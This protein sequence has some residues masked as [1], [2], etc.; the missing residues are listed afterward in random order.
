MNVM[1]PMAGRGSRFSAEGYRRPKP[2]INIVG[3]PMLFWILDNL[4]FEAE[5]TLWVGVH[6]ELEVEYAIEARLRKEYPSLDLR[7]VS[8]GFQTRGAAETLFIMLQQM[9]SV[10]VRRKSISLDC[11][12]IFFSDV[13]GSFRACSSGCGSS[14]YF[15][16]EGDKPIFSY[17]KFEPGTDNIVQVREKEAISRHANTGAYAFPC[18]DQ[19]RNACR[20]VL[21]NPVGKAGE[22]Y[23][24]SIIEGMIRAGQKFVGIH[25][26][27]FFCV[28]TPAQLRS[29][30]G[31][32]RT[33]VIKPRHKARVC[34]DL[35]RSLRIARSGSGAD[36]TAS[37]R[38]V[39]RILRLLQAL[40]DMGI[41]YDEIVFGKPAADVHVGQR[42]SNAH[43]DME[44]EIGWCLQESEIEEGASS[45]FAQH[46]IPPRSFNRVACSDNDLVVKAAPSEYLRG[47]LHF[48]RS[49]PPELTH[50][51]PTL[52]EV[53]DDPSLAMPSITITKASE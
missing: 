36:E 1:I 39:A 52:V 14:F 40:W 5:D 21:D 22:F 44:K 43:E 53:A 49:I 7:V 13:L 18:G 19:L 34:F 28:G 9:S 10:E 38:P 51:F 15:E 47:E 12:T 41:R 27:D 33:G 16:D 2:L 31:L 3:R 20:K 29:F 42:A 4:K 17:I 26:P 25:V 6:Q 24:S 32:V 45:C 23:T 30:L 48:Y 50:L 37:V 35:D 8:I 11:D 46:F